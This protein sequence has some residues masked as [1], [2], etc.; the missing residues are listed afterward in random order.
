MSRESPGV[1]QRGR[2][3]SGEHC[4]P[5][6]GP[7]RRDLL[8]LG[9]GGVVAGLAGCSLPASEADAPAPDPGTA[10]SS[11]RRSEFEP[12]DPPMETPWTGDV[13]PVNPRPEY[14]R[15]QLT[16]E[17]WLGLNGV[18]GFRPAE[19]G[20]SP[21]FGER[22][23]ET[24]L[25][26][27][28]VESAL[29]GVQREESRMWYR[30][31]FSVPEGWDERVHLHFEAADFETT[32]YVDGRT[33]SSHAGGYDPFAMDIT[34][35]LAEGGDDHE[36]VVGVVDPTDDGQQPL[37]KQR[38]EPEE[39]YYTSCSGIWGSVWL[40]PVPDPHVASLDTVPDPGNEE[41][42]LTVGTDA[43]DGTAATR[44]RATALADGTA[45]GTVTG[46]ADEELAV[47]VPDPR[48]WSP[49][50]PFLYDLRV[51]LLVEDDAVDTVGSYVGMRSV[52]METVD[53]APRFTLNGDPVFHMGT[54]DQGYWPDGVYTAPT[55]EALRA[56]LQAHVDMGFNAVR[57]HVKVEPRRW[58]YHADRLGLLVWQD[59]AASAVRGERPRESAREQFETGLRRMV[60]ELDSHPS[61]V[62][63]VPF[64]EGWGT[65]DVPRIVDL[66]RELDPSRPVDAQSGIGVCEGTGRI[67]G[68]RGAGDVLDYHNYPGPG[69]VPTGGDQAAVLGEYGGVGL[70]IEGHLWN[71]DREYAYASASDGAELT[72]I[73]V[74]KLAGVRAMAAGCGGLAAAFYTQLTDVEREINGL[75][76]YDRQVEKVDV[77]RVR[78]AHEA[79]FEAVDR[80]PG[81][82]ETATATEGDPAGVAYWPLDAGEESVAGDRVGGNDARFEDLLG[83]P[84][85]WADGRVGGA[86]AFDGDHD[87]L[88]TGVSVVDTSGPFGAAAWVRLAERGTD[89]A[90]VSQDGDGESAFA[91]EYR[92]G[93]GQFA[94]AVGT[95]AAVGGPAVE[96][97]R[98]YHVAGTVADC[99]ARL[100]VD[101]QEVASTTVGSTATGTEGRTVIGRGQAGGVVTDYWEGRIDEVH[102]YERALSA[103]DV[104]RLV[105][106]G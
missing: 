7:S 17:R 80:S 43:G 30:R 44:V 24:V 50:D 38:D 72:D 40:E 70:Q 96:A 37:G 61:V 55:D 12:G 106:E 20:E 3:S 13:D 32:V 49:D 34:D 78:R 31:T 47:P 99:T 2:R 89:R 33:V 57:K 69:S 68:P 101:G 23:P 18:W 41:V 95:S 87:V 9:A 82:G 56:D 1:E 46:S 71:P 52:G 35:A 36:L 60:A 76:T 39:I 94:F 84:P 79:L 25:V 62:A 65:F 28:P 67:C 73:Y 104:R 90:A 15:P 26:P 45:V 21:P 85:Q 75:L 53:G 51:E 98:W 66:S 88:D 6:A 11:A 93:P 86:V 100:Y 19:E 16:R 105:E 14:P 5:P 48:L 103:A 92:D 81:A 10:A 42:G 102:L 54:L 63:W 22:L 8:K 4:E 59:M 77:E 27:F 29:S 64:N 58:Y 91:L 97:D 74:Q 83:E